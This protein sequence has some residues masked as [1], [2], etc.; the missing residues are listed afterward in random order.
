V[1]RLYNIALILKDLKKYK[2]AEKRLREII[3]GCERAL[4]KEYLY[5]LEF[6][7]KLSIIYKKS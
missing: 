6:I 3:E 7:N 5:T 4:K 1:T 2:E